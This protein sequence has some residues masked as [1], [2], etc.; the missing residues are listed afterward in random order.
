M[1]KQ[2]YDIDV[3]SSYLIHLKKD[4]SYELIETEDMGLFAEDVLKNND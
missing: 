4:Q 1:L 2:E 3:H